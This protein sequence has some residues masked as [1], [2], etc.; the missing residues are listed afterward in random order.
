VKAEKPAKG[1]KAAKP[2][3]RAVALRKRA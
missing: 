1:E 2:P 3:V